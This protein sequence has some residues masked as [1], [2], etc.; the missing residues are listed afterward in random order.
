MTTLPPLSK[1]AILAINEYLMNEGT[2]YYVTARTE[3]EQVY[4]DT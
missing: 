3:V 1:C 4:F 2:T